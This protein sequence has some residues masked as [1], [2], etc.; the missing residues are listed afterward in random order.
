MSDKLPPLPKGAV[1]V[2]NMPP[3]PQGAVLQKETAYDRFLTS[4]RNPE[5][6]GSQA[7]VPFFLGGTGELIKGAGALTQMAFPNVGTRM[8]ETG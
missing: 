1:M 5:T 3:L 7:T 6:F 2:D 8:V 4:L